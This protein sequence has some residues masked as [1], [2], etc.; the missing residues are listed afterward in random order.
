VPLVYIWYTSAES[1]ITRV[2]FVDGW[3]ES[4]PLVLVPP[5]GRL[6]LEREEALH[7]AELAA[8]RIDRTHQRAT[9]EQEL[10]ARVVHDVTP[11]GRREP[12]VQRHRHDAGLRGAEIEHRVLGAVL[13]QERD[14]RA[15]SESLGDEGV[16]DLVRARERLAVRGLAAR[17]P[18]ERGVGPFTRVPVEEVE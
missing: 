4:Q 7:R 12:V 10:G 18:G 13:R 3:R 16:R 8:D 5:L 14:A 15:G 1:S 9:R 2:G 11:L 6:G 17:E